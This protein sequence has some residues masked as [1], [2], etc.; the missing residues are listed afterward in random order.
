[1][2]IVPSL[3]KT[4]AKARENSL[5]RSW[6]RNRGGV[7][8]SARSAARLLA[9][10]VSHDPVTFRVTARCS[11]RQSWFGT[12][13]SDSSGAASS[14]PSSKDHLLHPELP[15]RPH[16]GLR[17]RA[18]AEVRQ[19]WDDG[20]RVLKNSGLKC[21]SATKSRPEGLRQSCE[22]GGTYGSDASDRE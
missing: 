17:Y 12:R 20:Q 3:R 10:C 1:M 6:I 22:M 13:R 18:P 2:M 11:T 4:S 15:H 19:T 16:S 14:R 21:R 5:S 8:P 7:I 9:S